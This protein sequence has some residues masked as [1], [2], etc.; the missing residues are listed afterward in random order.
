MKSTWLL[1]GLFGSVSLVVTAPTGLSQ[2]N[3]QT[4]RQLI[5]TTRPLLK[6]NLDKILAQSAAGTGLKMWSYDVTSTRKGSIGKKYKGVMV[7]GNPLTSNGT[8]TITMQ[9]VP[10]IV[11]IQ[12]TV[13]DPTVPDAKCAG[14]KIP[15]KLIEQSPLVEPADFT[16][17]GV[18][19]GKTQYTDAF[20][21]AS[22]WD[23]V[24][25]NGGGYHN[26]LKVVVL[27]AIKIHPGSHGSIVFSHA[28]CGAFGGL[29]YFWF[30]KHLENRLIP[31]LQQQGL[32]NPTTFPFFVVYNVAFPFNGQC[33]VG[34]WHGSFGSPVQTYGIALFDTSGAFGSGYTTYGMS[35]EI[36]EWQDNPLF[37]FDLKTLG[38]PTPPWGHVGQVTGCQNDTE[39]GDPLTGTPPI[40]VTM[41]NHFTYDLQEM[42]FFSWFFGPPSIGAGGKFSSNGTFTSAPGPCH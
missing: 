7:G 28:P 3:E 1:F 21:R 2:S 24:S 23:A 15:L 41:P 18:D 25:K 20:R 4:P 8:T 42:A 26:R 17:N 40:R 9:I 5:F 10:L 32:V 36:G 16:M 14:G 33:C 11:D 12:G 37:F 38:N 34:G 35:H 39:V 31:S 29:D 30:T 22:F 27:P 6:G 13:F 19:M